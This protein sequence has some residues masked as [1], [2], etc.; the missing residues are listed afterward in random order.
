MRTP[1]PLSLHAWL[2]FD[3]VARLLPSNART[4]LEI[5][6]GLGSM[7]VLLA[8]RYAYVGL[9]P[10]AASRAVAERRLVAASGT[11]LASD[12]ASFA[13]SEP[14]DIVCAF[15]VLE[16]LPHDEAAVSR[17]RN[18][19]RPGGWLLVSVPLGAARVGAADARAGH[20]RRYDRDDLEHVL[21][22]AGLQE[23]AVLAYG[24]PF[25]YALEAA[26]NLLSR[27]SMSD[28]STAE[29]RTARSGRW[30]QPPDWTA[31]GTHA[32]A[33]PF[34]LIQRPFGRSALGTGLVARARRPP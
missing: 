11:V 4:L 14:F 26:R 22:G 16:H 19:V 33:L 3:A 20:V 6:A 25:G 17:W 12:D 13:P 8:E 28:S 7:G 5:G 34:R 23:I 2:R 18:L 27:R 1:P 24:F 9:E 15:E 29:E 32:A 31:R 21:A 10:D 30:L